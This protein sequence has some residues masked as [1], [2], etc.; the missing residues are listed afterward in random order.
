MTRLLHTSSHTCTCNH[1]ARSGKRFACDI[2]HEEGTD[3]HE[4]A[5]AKRMVGPRPHTAH[6]AAC[7]ARRACRPASAA[8][9]PAVL[10]LTP[11]HTSLVPRHASTHPW[12]HPPGVTRVT[13]PQTCGYCSAEQAVADA[14][15]ACGKRLAST[16]A[17]P[18]GRLTRFWEG[19][20]GCRDPNQMSKKGARPQLPTPNYG[21]P[22][23]ACAWILAWSRHTPRLALFVRTG[24]AARRRAARR[25]RSPLQHRCGTSSGP[26]QSPACTPNPLP[27][28]TLGGTATA[29]PR[30][31]VQRAS[32]SAPSPGADPAA[33]GFSWCGLSLEWLPAR[34]SWPVQR[35]VVLLELVGGATPQGSHAGPSCVLDAWPPPEVSCLYARRRAPDRQ[36]SCGQ[37]GG[38]RARGIS[39]PRTHAPGPRVGP[40]KRALKSPR[41]LSRGIPST[42]TRRRGGA[43]RLRCSVLSQCSGRLGAACERQ[44]HARQ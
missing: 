31:R 25:G 20:Q 27:P 28:Q 44:R 40:R 32:A 36:A 13:R 34:V 9:G 26:T 8:A 10:M 35:R 24:R 38:A 42:V 41:K 16:A 11:P 29:R 5:W 14:C 21:L 6:A 4:M 23:P 1:P 33:A 43:P 22:V 37:R 2:C 30:P 7:T 19:G 15:A 12:R 3:G 17:N 39:L 18:S